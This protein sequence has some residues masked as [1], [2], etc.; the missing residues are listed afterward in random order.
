MK[1]EKQIRDYLALCKEQHEYNKKN[2]NK[3][4]VLIGD[5]VINTLNYILEESTNEVII[6]EV[7]KTNRFYV[8]GLDVTDCKYFK[9]FYCRDLWRK[10]EIC[11]A[12]K[13]CDFK[14][15]MTSQNAR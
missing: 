13:N 3:Y 5:A 2:D 7:K 15:N 1:N 9:E 10:K 12:N 11:K 6:A 4:M 8:D 14:K